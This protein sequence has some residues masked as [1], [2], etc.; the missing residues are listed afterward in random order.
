MRPD[1]ASG[2]YALGFVLR[3]LQQVPEAR[4]EFEKSIQLQPVQTESYFCLGLLDL[5]ENKLADASKHFAEALKQ[6]PKHAGALTGV[7]RV[8]FQR[9]QYLSAVDVLQQAIAS[10]PNLREAHYYLGMAYGR[11]GRSDDSQKELQRAGQLDRE[12]VQKQKY[13][14]KLLNPDEEAGA[15]A[16]KPK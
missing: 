14:L 3:A 10:D 8:A 12:E 5:D 7:G 9:K 6:D 15:G 2:Y 16:T 4:Q 13:V 1:D 11:L